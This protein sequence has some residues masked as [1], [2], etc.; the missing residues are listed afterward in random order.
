[1]ELSHCHDIL[2]GLLNA[3]ELRVD[4]SPVVRTAI[5]RSRE[6]ADFRNAVIAELGQLAGC[7]HTVTFDRRAAQLPGMRLVGEDRLA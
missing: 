5:E 3:K 6:G 2:E 1:L 4:R 7:A